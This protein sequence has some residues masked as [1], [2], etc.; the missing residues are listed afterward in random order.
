M[1]RFTKVVIVASVVLAAAIVVGSKPPQQTNV[2]QAPTTVAFPG[3]AARPAAE[4]SALATA[5]AAEPKA[6]LA[7][8]P[9]AATVP[10]AGIPRLVDLG[11]DQCIPCKLMAPILEELRREYAG[12]MHVEFIDVWKH[13]HAARPYRIYAIPTQIFYDASG[14]ELARHQGYISKEDIL[15]TWKR[16]GIDFAAGKS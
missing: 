14:R 8:A 12:R 4:P 9:K 1:S 5:P 13:P 2:S 10:A 11:A 16:L 7:P 3:E 15:S 6:A